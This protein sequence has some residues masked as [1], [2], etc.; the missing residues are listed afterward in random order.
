MI[1]R[2]VRGR[3]LRNKI[4]GDGSTRGGEMDSTVKTTGSAGHGGS[5]TNS[6]ANRETCKTTFIYYHFPTTLPTETSSVFDLILG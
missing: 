1:G 5:N 3:I 4:G 6:E 2:R